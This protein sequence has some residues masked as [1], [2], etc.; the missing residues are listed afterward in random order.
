LLIVSKRLGYLRNEIDGGS[1]L[2]WPGRCFRAIAWIN[3][4]VQ[5]LNEKFD[6]GQTDI[7]D[8]QKGWSLFALEFTINGLSAVGE[9]VGNE[10]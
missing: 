2:L 3:T 7:G 5:A 6:L 4:D 1:R 10:C 9:G 8:L